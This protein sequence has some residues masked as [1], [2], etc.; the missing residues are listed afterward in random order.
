MLLKA[1]LSGWLDVEPFDR[2]CCMNAKTT[3]ECSFSR[4]VDDSLLRDRVAER[5]ILRTVV[6]LRS[7]GR[8][9]TLGMK[10]QAVEGWL[11]GLEETAY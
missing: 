1:R 11:T 3:L 2:P 5:Y 7:N 8:V 4:R 9:E 10:N 6:K